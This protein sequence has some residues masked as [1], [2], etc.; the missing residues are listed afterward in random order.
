MI[1]S[2]LP[3]LSLKLKKKLRGIRKRNPLLEI[4]LV[5]I[6][7]KVNKSKCL[8]QMHRIM[9]KCQKNKIYLKFKKNKEEKL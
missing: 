6:L 7:M 5:M 9:F 4:Y 1:S 8:N 2:L 3:K